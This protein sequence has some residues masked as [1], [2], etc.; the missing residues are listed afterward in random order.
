MKLAI[1]HENWDSGAARCARDLERGLS[2][3][4]EVVYFPREGCTTASRILGELDA[5]GPDAVNCHAFYSQ[6]PYSFLARVSRRYPTCFTVHDPRPIGSIEVPCWDCDRNAWCV[7]CPMVRGRWRKLLANPYARRRSWKR[8]QHARCARDLRVVSPSRWLRDRLGRQELRQF[9]LRTIP[10][11][12][13]L[14]RFRPVPGARERLGLPP[15]APMVLHVA[16]SERSGHYSERKGLRYVVAAFES[17]VI[18]RVPGALLAVA[19]EDAVP[20]RPW[21]RPLG[22]LAPSDL[23]CWLS[24]ADIFVAATLADNL[25]YTI[26]E[27]MGCGRPVVASGIGG[28]PEQ[29]VDGENGRLVPARDAEALGEALADLLGDPGRR[30]AYGE[31]SRRRAEALFA[32]PRF[33]GDYEAL[34]REMIA[35]R[36]GPSTRR[37][38]FSRQD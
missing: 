33:L 2:A 38:Q 19:G 31:A 4:H 5:F 27:A 15:D 34:F 11:G 12:V 24:A 10:Y 25:P 35:A 8:W 36:R 23:P 6:L 32:M 17:H 9:D 30:L 20:N 14:E 1:V 37:R 3:A 26:L 21:I 22:K 13:D 18:P 7:R 28:V 29:V 16:A